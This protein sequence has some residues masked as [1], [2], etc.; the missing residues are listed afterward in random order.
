MN[1]HDDMILFF[2][3]TRNARKLKQIKRIFHIVLI[4]KN[5]IESSI[6]YRINEKDKERKKNSC[7]AYLYYA[8]FLLLYT[9]ETSSDKEIASYELKSWFLDHECR[10]NILVKKLALEICLL[11]LK[12][13]YINN[14]TKEKIK[15]FIKEC[16]G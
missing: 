16:R 10:N 12:N 4:R 14:R 9:K 13:Q 3:L 15:T 5:P 2:L 8:E 7:F 6:I 1:V 11:Y